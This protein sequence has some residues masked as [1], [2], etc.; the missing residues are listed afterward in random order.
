M[1]FDKDLIPLN[2]LNLKQ[3]LNLEDM[4]DKFL[5]SFSQLKDKSL[6]II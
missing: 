3:Q 1:D 4:Q 2:Y 6:Q 5:I